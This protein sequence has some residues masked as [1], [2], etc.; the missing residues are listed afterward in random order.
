MEPSLPAPSGAFSVSGPLMSHDPSHGTVD[1]AQ[2]IQP[3]LDSGKDFDMEGEELWCHTTIR[4]RPG[5]GSIVGGGWLRSDANPYVV[6]AEPGYDFSRW[7]TNIW[8]EGT[9][10]PWPMAD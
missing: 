10:R 7:E 5:S 6:Y 4:V 8:R 3:V 9:K 1:A 2:R